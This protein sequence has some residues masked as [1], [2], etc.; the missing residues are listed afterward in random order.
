MVPPMIAPVLSTPP[1]AADTSGAW[2]AG[3]WVEDDVAVVEE[4]EVGLEVEDD[5]DLEP[6]GVNVNETEMLDIGSELPLLIEVATR[7]PKVDAVPHPYWKKPPSK[8]FL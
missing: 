3:D 1:F 2:V 7:V 5:D 4:D 8:V 6:V